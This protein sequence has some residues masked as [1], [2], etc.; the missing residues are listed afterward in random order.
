M[1][2][3]LKI[4]KFI[5][6]NIQDYHQKILSKLLKL[7]LSTIL[8]RKNPYLFK[9]KSIITSQELVKS[10]LDAHLISQEE[11]IFGGFLEQLALFVCQVTYQAKKSAAEGI[12]IEFEKDSI[13][14]IVSIKSGPNWGNSSQIAKMKDNFQKAKKILRSNQSKINIVAVN[15]CCYGQDKKPDKGSYLKLC[16][17]S[18]W[19]LVSGMEN[20]YIDII[21][22]MGQ[23]A[24]KHDKKFDVEYS[25]IINQFT[26]EFSKNYCSSKGK[27]L[28][29]KIIQF[30]SQK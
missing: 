30:N 2:L 5:E 4:E 11:G 26:L 12:D 1:T 16:G 13:F 27:I 22:P 17:Q 24:K 23:K 10:I 21:K 19:E 15:G 29:E 3:M 14:Y 6:D 28:W 25:K 18:F 7:K 20:L 8:K 9:A